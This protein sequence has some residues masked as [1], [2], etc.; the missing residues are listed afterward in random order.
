MK[1]RRVVLLDAGLLSVA[2][3][4]A[5]CALAIQQAGR[6]LGLPVVVVGRTTA[7]RELRA[8]FSCYRP[9]LTHGTYPVSCRGVLSIASA[10][11]QITANEKL[12]SDDL[13]LLPSCHVNEILG[14]E[15]F[16]RSSA[17]TGFPR[18]AMQFHQLMPPAADS[19][20]AV[21][22]HYE[23]RWYMRLQR[24]FRILRNGVGGPSCSTTMC[25][26]LNRLYRE[27]SGR[28]IGVLPFP[29]YRSEDGVAPR[30]R[31]TDHVKMAFLGDGRAE[32]GLGTLLRAIPLTRSPEFLVQVLPLRG[33]GQDRQEEL[34]GQLLTIEDN[35]R[36][37][38]VR[39]A[40]PAWRFHAVLGACDAVV[41]PYE[42]RHYAQ[43]ASMIFVQAVLHGKP[44]I[45]PSGTWMASELDAGRA[46]GIVWPWEENK[47]DVDRAT[48]LAA[49][50]E[51]LAARINEYEEIARSCLAHYASSHTPEEYLARVASAE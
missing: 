50:I 38:V 46:A 47:T 36:V 2:G 31:R 11:A 27:L 23:T 5:E 32:K 14:V 7:S 28:P 40:L 43:R 24:A 15:R 4:P 6:G 21:T 44:V 37:E 35:A 51:N 3:H 25:E 18:M 1:V 41:L 34:Q 17:V 30:R 8:T 19:N 22:S 16:F 42:P 49:K 26:P 13:V 48:L 45:V 29:V 12:V 39:E 33:F 9:L 10:L 20:I